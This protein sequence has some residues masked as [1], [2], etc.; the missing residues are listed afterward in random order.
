[1]SFQVYTP[2]I[3]QAPVPKLPDDNVTLTTRRPTF[4]VANAQ[5]SGPAGAIQYQ[6]EVATDAA[7]SA[8]VISVLV[9]EGSGDTSYTATADLAYATRYYW[10]VKA[11]DTGHESGYS[12]VRSFTTPDPPPVPPTAP[13]APGAPAAG[14]DINVA[15]VQFWNSPNVSGWPTTA[16]ITSVDFSRGYIEVDFDRRTGPNA[17]P[18]VSSESFGPLQYTLGMCFNLSNSWHCSAPV[19]FWAGRE[20]PAS[21]PASQV[22]QNWFYD[23]IRWGPM[24]GH[25]P[26]N[27]E[28]VAIWVGQ[29]NLRGLGGATLQERS[30]FVLVKFGVNYP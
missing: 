30:N 13:P 11:M 27:G 8:K 19:Q 14:D 9:N 26:A 6:F 12:T 24:A 17:W 16:R 10:R 29:G 25:Q 15:A 20:L 1:M 21:G 2:V 18:E 4:V 22:A 7:I 5:R 3:I 23:S 28:T